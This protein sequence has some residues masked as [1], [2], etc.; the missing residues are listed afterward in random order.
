M[1]YFH[2]RSDMTT[3][4]N[5][6]SRHLISFRTDP[7]NSQT[8]LR[9]HT[10]TILHP[11]S[12]IPSVSATSGRNNSSHS[13]PSY[14][15]SS[16]VLT[17]S[18]I[19]GYSPSPSLFRS[20]YSQHPA[21]APVLNVCIMSTESLIR[22]TVLV[23]RKP[24]TTEEEFSKYWAYKHGPL[25]TDWLKRNGIIKYVQVNSP[26]AS[27][28]LPS[29]H[30]S[31]TTLSPYLLSSHKTQ[32]HTTSAYKALGQKMFDATGRSPLAYDG[33]GDFWVRK[34][35]DFE[36]AFLDPYY[37]EVIQPDEKELIDME[38]IAVTIGV[39]YVVIEEGEIVERH[40]RKF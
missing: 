8:Y 34:Y 21:P 7:P 32:Y 10:P 23:N 35:E 33:M 28:Y 12:S 20:S 40:A 15:I 19:C 2:L 5:R 38:S 9:P 31:P 36:A 14:S 26:L 37:Q 3:Y 24:G 22:V 11:L 25:A 29:P 30:S 4:L 17:L 1:N 6:I 27:L 39:E 13:L 16:V 18:S